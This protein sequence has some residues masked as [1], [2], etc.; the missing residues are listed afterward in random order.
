MAAE[1]DPTYFDPSHVDP[2]QARDVARWRK[3]ER[4]RLRAERDAMSVADRAALGQAIGAHLLQFLADRFGSLEGRVFSGYWPIKGEPDLRPALAKLHRAGARVALPLV[5]VKAAPLVFRRWTPET[6]MLRGD[7]NIPV[8]PPE[9]EAMLPE[10]ALAPVVGWSEGAF[11][12]GYGG[13]YFDRTLA[14][15]APRPFTIGIGLQSA[16]LATIFPQPHDIALDVILT[17]AGVQ[18]EAV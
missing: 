15:L 12:L 7:W 9:A 5:E 13:G 16:R 11:R 3:A 8:P 18:A 17:E 10:I 4:Q 6:K 1:V 14:A 2:E